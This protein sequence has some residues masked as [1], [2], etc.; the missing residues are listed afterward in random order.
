MYSFGP[1]IGTSLL[2]DV[3]ISIDDEVVVAAAAVIGLMVDVFVARIVV[4]NVDDDDDVVVVVVVILAVA[5]L[6]FEFEFESNVIPSNRSSTAFSALFWPS[7]NNTNGSSLK[8]RI[9][10]YVLFFYK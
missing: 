10:L 2:F 4:V 7:H 3:D 6:L 1:F 9:I 5:V 8:K